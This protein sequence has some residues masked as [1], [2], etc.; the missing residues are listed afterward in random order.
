MLSTARLVRRMTG[1]TM[2]QN[3]LEP[4]RRRRCRPTLSSLV[5]AIHIRATRA[6]NKNTGRP[7]KSVKI[8]AETNTIHLNAALAAGTRGDL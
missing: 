7:T 8:Q 3:A 1:Q 2:L 6:A 4:A 5:A